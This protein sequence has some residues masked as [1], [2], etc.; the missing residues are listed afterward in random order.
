VL[1]NDEIFRDLK[2]LEAILDKDIDKGVST[3]MMGRKKR[4]HR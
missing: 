1:T 2:E 4:A 3:R